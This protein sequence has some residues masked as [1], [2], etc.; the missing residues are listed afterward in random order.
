MSQVMSAR[1]E[2]AV[3]SSSSQPWCQVMSM[4]DAPAGSAIAMRPSGRGSLVA[5]ELLRVMRQLG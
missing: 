2:I 4:V 5:G 3:P 1:S